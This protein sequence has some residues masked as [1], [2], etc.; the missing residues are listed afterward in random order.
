MP[1]LLAKQTRITVKTTKIIKFQVFEV[2][3]ENRSSTVEALYNTWSPL[4]QKVKAK[5]NAV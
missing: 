2:K 3:V 1:F 5:N 4:L